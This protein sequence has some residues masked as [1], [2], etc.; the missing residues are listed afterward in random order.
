MAGGASRP[1]T[2]TLT[3][4]SFSSVSEQLSMMAWATTERH[5]ST[6]WDLL[7]SNTNSGFLT[8]LT[9]NLRARLGWGEKMEKDEGVR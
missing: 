2:H 8:R 5:A 6:V 1:D 7:T 3:R 4:V 9:Q